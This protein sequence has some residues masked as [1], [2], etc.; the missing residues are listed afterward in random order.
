M[1]GTFFGK[2]HRSNF[3][4]LGLRSQLGAGGI[5]RHPAG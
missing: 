3:S 5:G 4:R 2:R 1:G